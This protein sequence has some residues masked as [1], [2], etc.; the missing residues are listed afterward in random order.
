M[1]YI[2]LYG[3]QNG[4]CF[5]YLVDNIQDGIDKLWN[6]RKKCLDRMEYN[7]VYPDN[8]KNYFYSEME[9]YSLFSPYDRDSDSYEFYQMIELK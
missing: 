5:H 4:V 6:Q 1:K 3:G 8:D 2:A 9:E 7:P